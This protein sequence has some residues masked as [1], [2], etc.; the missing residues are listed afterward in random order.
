MFYGSDVRLPQIRVLGDRMYGISEHHV[1]TMIHTRTVVALRFP[2]ATGTVRPQVFLPRMKQLAKE[3]TY[4]ST[5]SGF[6]ICAAG[7]GD[8]SAK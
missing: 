5:L 1:D 7:A 2:T 3:I 4:M 8:I 6:I